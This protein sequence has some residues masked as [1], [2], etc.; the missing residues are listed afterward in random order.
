MAT[1]KGDVHDIGK[2]IVGVVLQC[3]NYEV[4]DLGVMVPAAKILETAK[5]EE[6]DIIGLS[7]LITPSLDEM[8]H[9]AAEMERQGFDLPLLIGGATTSRVH[10]AVKIHPNYRRGQAVYVTDASRAVGVAQ[11]LMSA[12]DA[13]RL[14]RRGAR[15]IR[16]DRRR[17]C[18]RAGG[19]AAAAACRRRAPMRV[20]LDWS[21]AYQ[22]PKPSIPRHPGAQ[23]LPGRRT[24]RLHRLD[25]VLPDL[26]AG[27]QVSGHPRRRQ[28]RARRRARSTTM[29]ARCCERIVAE[30]WFKARAAFG[31]WPA[32]A[33]GD[34]ILVYADETRAERRSPRCIRCASSCP[35]AKAAPIGRWP[36]SSRRA[37]SGL[38]DYIG[39]FAV[40]AG[41]GEDEVAE[42]FKRANDDYSAIMVK[43]LADRLA[44]AFAERLHQRVRKE[45]WGYAPDEA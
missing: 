21:G 31:F 30:R 26:G 35:S 36:I 19:Q 1:V 39:A 22:P 13:A 37:T 41:I 40:T 7:G 6:A 8:C 17:A 44:E 29:R 43:A 18:A 27:R 23:R 15:R 12:A 2:N 32:N 5:A 25:A 14:C 16:Q 10:T 4:I 9:V 34:D 28:G 24:D 33:Q 11:A 20:K 42:R 45:F 38:A 3:N